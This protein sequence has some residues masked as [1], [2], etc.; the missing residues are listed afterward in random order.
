M[1]FLALHIGVWLLIAF[2]LGLGAG[3]LLWGSLVGIDMTP[4]FERPKSDGNTDAGSFKILSD[5]L[6]EAQQELE[7]CR[8]SLAD[9][10]ARLQVTDIRFKNDK[11]EPV[12][13]EE[14]SEEEVMEESDF[15]SSEAIGTLDSIG[16]AEIVG[17]TED[18]VD[19]LKK[20]F[21]IGPVI[22]KKL[23]E[24][25]ITTY[26]QIGLL[27]SGEIESVCEHLNYFPGRVERDGW[28]ENAKLLYKKKYGQDLSE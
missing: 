18:S 25:G 7:Q 27:S 1:V 17:V 13:Q 6:M 12:V 21:G 26:R 19:D 16:V 24:L 3:W 9:A 28:L 5:S 23:N 14:K 15:N 11:V 20:I 10:E 8:Q 4:Q 2:G 22:E